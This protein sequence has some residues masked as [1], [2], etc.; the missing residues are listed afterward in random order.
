MHS[1]RGALFAASAL[2]FAS[3]TSALP[4]DVASVARRSAELKLTANAPASV[5]DVLNTL[6]V[7][8]GDISAN[9]KAISA[10][11]PT[12]SKAETSS[13]LSSQNS[14]LEDVLNT[15][16]EGLTKFVGE[17][18]GD[19]NLLDLAGTVVDIVAD[20]T[21]ALVTV[22]KALELDPALAPLVE[23]L[24]GL[25]NGPLVSILGLVTGLTSALLPIIQGLLTTLGLDPLLAELQG[26]VGA[27]L[28]VL[29][30]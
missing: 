22:E 20:L 16:V 17:I 15:A 19:L 3:A 25:L 27:L 11:A 1:F 10:A 12:S 24:A 18:K 14:V 8:T 28:T 9:I 23:T 7:K 2:F 4:T 26:L 21:T 30:L 29:G 13:K 5:Q 6:K